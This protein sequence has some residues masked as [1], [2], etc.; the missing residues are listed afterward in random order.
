VSITAPEIQLF[1]IKNLFYPNYTALEHA[2]IITLPHACL[3]WWPSTY[4]YGGVPKIRLVLVLYRD[5]HY[6]SIC[7]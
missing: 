6:R 3:G 2:L 4:P 7:Q 5:S 1:L